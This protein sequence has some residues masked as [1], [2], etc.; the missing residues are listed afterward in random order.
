[1]NYILLSEF[2][3]WCIDWNNNQMYHKIHSPCNKRQDDLENFWSIIRG[4]NIYLL[5][6]KMHK[7]LYIEIHYGNV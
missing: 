6:F 4:C 7:T 5:I 1:M 3:G 2:V